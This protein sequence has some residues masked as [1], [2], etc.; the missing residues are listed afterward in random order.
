MALLESAV[1]DL[2][3]GI[4]KQDIP[5][6]QAALQALV[7]SAVTDVTQQIVPALKAT[8][9]NL[10]GEIGDELHGVLDRLNGTKVALTPG[11]F[12]L[13]IPPRKP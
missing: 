3:A 13:V 4:S 1:Q 11:G 6:A 2:V 7:D 12:E 10:A 8:A 5:A 9:S